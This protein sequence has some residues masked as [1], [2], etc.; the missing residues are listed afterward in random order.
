[1]RAVAR[2]PPKRKSGVCMAVPGEGHLNAVSL[3]LAL[4]YS[5]KRLCDLLAL[6]LDAE[7]L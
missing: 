6:L 2:E 5:A 4:R 3:S 7:R 1:M